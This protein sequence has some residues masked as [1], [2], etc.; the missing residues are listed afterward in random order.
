MFQTFILLSI[1]NF[2]TMYVG[3]LV[4]KLNVRTGIERGWPK[5]IHDAFPG[6]PNDIDAGIVFKGDFHL[7]K[8]YIFLLPLL[9]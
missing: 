6:L 1:H 9:L 4:W 2:I 3:K 7:F 5:L 8:V